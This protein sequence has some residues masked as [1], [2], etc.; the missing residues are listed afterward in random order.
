MK[1][2]F[3]NNQKIALMISIV[4]AFISL[5]GWARASGYNS[6]F[7]SDLTFET[8]AQAQKV[9]EWVN[10][11]DRIIF[12]QDLQEKLL[13]LKRDIYASDTLIS[14]KHNTDIDKLIQVIN[15]NTEVTTSTNQ[16][17]QKLLDIVLKQK[18]K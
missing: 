9:I 12:E 14:K 4:T 1:N 15:H 8:P 2:F 16:L 3:N 7:N 6:R 10:K 17:T 13:N 11:G 5:L 18:Y